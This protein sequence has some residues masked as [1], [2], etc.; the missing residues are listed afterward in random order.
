MSI[1]MPIRSRRISPRAA[2]QNRH[3]RRT[4]DAPRSGRRHQASAAAPRADPFLL[5][6]TDAFWIEGPRSNIARLADAFDPEAMD[7]MLLVAAAAGGGRRRL[8]RR[9]HHDPGRPALGPGAAACGAL[10]LYRR[11]YRQS[12][13]CSRTRRQD[14]FRLAPFFHAAAARGRLFGVRLDGLWIHVGRPETIAE[15]EVAIQRSIL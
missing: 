12:L 10:R 13:S 5:C 15:A 3:L 1:G 8:A 4:G 9:L 2:R 11:R 14:V 6:N 7:V